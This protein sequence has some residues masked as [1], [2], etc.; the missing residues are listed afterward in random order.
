TFEADLLDLGECCH[1]L[2]SLWKNGLKWCG[3]PLSWH[4][5]QPPARGRAGARREPQVAQPTIVRAA[6][7]NAKLRRQAASAR[8]RKKGDVSRRRF[9]SSRRTTADSDAARRSP[10]ALSHRPRGRSVAASRWGRRVEED[11]RQILLEPAA[12]GSRAALLSC[13]RQRPLD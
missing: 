3:N 7:E 5:R 8:D 13:R 6:Q 4:I 2:L 9:N 11:K 10:R 1:D 12:P